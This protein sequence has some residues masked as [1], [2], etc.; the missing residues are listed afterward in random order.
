ME[1]ARVVAV[2]V[3][4][5]SG[6]RLG[7]DVPKALRTIGGRPVVAVAV[8][9]ALSS[10]A[11]DAVVV[12]SPPGSEDAVREMFAGSSDAVIVVTGGSTRQRSVAAGLDAVGGLVE[13]VVVHDAARPF[14]SPALFAAVVHAV[15]AGADAAVPV[16]PLVDTVKRVQ[17]GTIVGTQ[18]RDG[19]ALAQT[20]QACRLHLLRDAVARAEASDLDFTDDSGL[21]EWAG[22]SV[23]TVD[24]EPGNVKI[25]TASD[26]A[27]AD[28]LSGAA[29]D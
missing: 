25:T 15:E 4:A 20:P 2:V 16:L 1:R 27:R 18:P 23:R 29:R 10:P 28:E 17:D 9:R 12:V 24:G 14:A 22:A 5:G 26:L 21:M 6:A 8:D 3:A 11:I 13:V 19:L 7:G